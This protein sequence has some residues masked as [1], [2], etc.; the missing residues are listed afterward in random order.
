MSLGVHKGYHTHQ[1]RQAASG[2]FA[3]PNQPYIQPDPSDAASASSSSN[4]PALPSIEASTSSDTGTAA[5]AV[6]PTD[7]SPMLLVDS[8]HVH[9]PDSTAA[10]SSLTQI[11]DAPQSLILIQL[12]GHF[13]HLFYL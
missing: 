7:T 9:Q 12:T 4:Q 5:S 6:I 10:D 3:S 2:S 8:A 1:A 13:F 11:S